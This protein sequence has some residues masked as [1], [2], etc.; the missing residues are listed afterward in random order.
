MYDERKRKRHKR[1][2][3]K[4][5]FWLQ[6][7]LVRIVV[8]IIML[9]PVEKS[10]AFAA[11]LGRGLW[12]YYHR[13]RE[14]ALINLKIAFPEKNDAWR[15][16]I[17]KCSFEHVLMLVIDIFY[18]P[19]LV[20]KENWKKYSTYVNCER[21]KWM[22]AEHKGM[23][24][25]AC[26]YGNFEIMG[27]ILGLFGFDIYSI[28]RPLDNP[29]LNKYL[30]GVRERKGQK[31]INKKGASNDISE[32]VQKGATLCF[33]GDQDGGKKGWFIDFFNRKASAYKSIALAAVYYNV[34]V[35]VGMCR[36]VE[37][38]FF[39]EIETVGI[40]TPDQWAG[41]ENPALWVTQRYNSLLEEGIRKDPS[42][43]W[44]LHRRWKTRPKDEKKS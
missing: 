32:I 20:K 1:K 19:K 43:Y 37:N 34:P 27:Y 9:F 23:L 14:R 38:R 13:G 11:W 30:Y 25:V 33:I 16:R 17:G 18:T 41:K 35:G 4:I 8:F 26:H 44:W 29:Y 36:R 12:K 10:L 15:E 5:E 31:I 3:T 6:Y 40:I 28:A 42:Q 24:M 2:P 21:T 22:I 39:F 7:V